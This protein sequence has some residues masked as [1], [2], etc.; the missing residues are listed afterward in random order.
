MI[1][2]PVPSRTYT[3]FQDV[4]RQRSMGDDGSEMKSVVDDG[5]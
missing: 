5:P 4:A 3:H 1:K 2:W